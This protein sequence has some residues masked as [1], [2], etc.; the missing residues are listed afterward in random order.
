MKDLVGKK[1][2]IPEGTPDDD[3]LLKTVMQFYGLKADDIVKTAPAEIGESLR[4][5]RVAA[6]LAMGP[7][8]PG[9]LSDAVKAIVKATKK[10]AEIH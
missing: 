5:K 10:T 8:G 6:F 2:A 4:D 7:S 3:P 1:I 9:A